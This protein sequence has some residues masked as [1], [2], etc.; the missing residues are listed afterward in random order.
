M[1]QAIDF[2]K[3]ILRKKQAIRE[4]KSIRLCRDYQK[5][6]DKSIKELRYYCKTTGLN[7][8]LVMAEASKR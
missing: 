7:Y 3:E 8:R 6:V 5:S 1:K 2:A 4:S